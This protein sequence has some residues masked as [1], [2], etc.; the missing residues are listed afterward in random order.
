M[1][2]DRRGHQRTTNVF[3]TLDSKFRFKRAK[4][5]ISGLRANLI[6]IKIRKRYRYSTVSLFIQLSVVCNDKRQRRKKTP[7]IAW[8]DPPKR[9]KNFH[10]SPLE[11]Y[12]K[13][14]LV[15]FT[16]MVLIL[17]QY[18]ICYSSSCRSTIWDR[19][20]AR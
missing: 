14:A 19:V 13:K 20:Q 9:K 16:M 4:I 10:Y 15:L 2:G 8:P 3:V 18:T 5:L 1:G 12:F 7:R 17:V 6:F 11:Q